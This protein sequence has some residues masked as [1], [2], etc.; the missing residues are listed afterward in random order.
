MQGDKD[1]L[2]KSLLKII[3]VMGHKATE[4]QKKIFEFVEHGTG[5]GIID[6]V[7]EKRQ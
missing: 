1:Y 7:V 5:N 4:A 3:Y 2:H 6:A